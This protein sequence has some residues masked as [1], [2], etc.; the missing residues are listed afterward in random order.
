MNRVISV[1]EKCN[2]PLPP[3]VLV[4]AQNAN[5][6]LLPSLTGDMQA[7]PAVLPEV[8]EIA[9]RFIF[10]AGT[11]AAYIAL[12]SNASSAN[13]NIILQPGSQLD[14][15]DHGQKVC[16]MCTDAAGTTIVATTIVRMDR[17]STN[18]ILVAQP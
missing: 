16:G 2:F 17:V 1:V 11:K 7:S 13:Y 18:N 14:C 10:N 9:S 6:E 12:G 8:R 15:S 5:V 3:D 4:L